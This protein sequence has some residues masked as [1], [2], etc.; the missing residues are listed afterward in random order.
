MKDLATMKK[1]SPVDLTFRDDEESKESGY[2][3]KLEIN[4]VA[5]QIEEVK[6]PHMSISRHY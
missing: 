2:V 6:E 4:S 5:Q 1:P 3:E